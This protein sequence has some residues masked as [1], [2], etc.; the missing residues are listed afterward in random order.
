VADVLC[1]IVVGR[2]EEISA[3]GHALHKA[4]AGEGRVVCI[5]GEAGIGKSR[6]AREVIALARAVAQAPLSEGPFPPEP[7]SLTDPSPKPSLN[8]SVIAHSRQLR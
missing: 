7:R 4:M 8:S 2:H 1:P 5:T 6:L 3:L